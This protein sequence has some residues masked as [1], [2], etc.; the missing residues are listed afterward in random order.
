MEYSIVT[1]RGSTRFKNGKEVYY[2]SKDF[3]LFPA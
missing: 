3:G 1:L 2:L